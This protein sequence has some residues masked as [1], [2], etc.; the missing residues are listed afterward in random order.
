M[1]V[2]GLRPG[3]VLGLGSPE[4]ESD[5]AL[6]DD[7]AEAGRDGS[8][9]A[10][11]AGPEVGGGTEADSWGT[12]GRIG[13]LASLS[14]V[15]VDEGTTFRAADVAVG[16]MSRLPRGRADSDNFDTVEGPAFGAADTAMRDCVRGA[17]RLTVVGRATGIFSGDGTGPAGARLRGGSSAVCFDSCR[18]TVGAEAA[19]ASRAA[20][21][22]SSTEG[23]VATETGVGAGSSGGEGSA[24]GVVEVGLGRS[25]SGGGD[26]L[27]GRLRSPSLSGTTDTKLACAGGSMAGA[28]IDK[29]VVSLVA[30]QAGSEEAHVVGTALAPPEARPPARPQPGRR[31]HSRP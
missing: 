10:S 3:L 7:A 30:R 6:E 4:A 2:G 14:L 21:L 26:G 20:R 9:N 19:N 29:I 28:E 12:A 11:A 17:S 15:A 25:V 27:D 1:L 31:A 22:A 13:R 8:T 18:L 24:V 23:V 16:C 5:D